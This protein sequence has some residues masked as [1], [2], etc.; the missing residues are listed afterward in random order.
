MKSQ[1]AFAAALVL[2]LIGGASIAKAQTTP[3]VT[4]TGTAKIEQMPTIVRMHI[5]LSGKG[6]AVRE[7]LAGLKDR[8]E[9]ATVNLEALGARKESIKVGE[10]TIGAATDERSRQMEMMIRQRMAGRQRGK[11]PEVKKPVTVTATMT[12]EWV[13]PSGSPED[14]LVAAHELQEKIKAA[15]LAGM[16]EAEKLS[17]EEEELAEEMS[18]VDTYG[19]EEAA[20]PGEPA[21]QYVVRITDDQHKKLVAEAFTKARDQAASLARAAGSQLG[22]LQQLQSHETESMH[23]TEIYSRMGYRYASSPYV[24]QANE[25][26]REAVGDAP[27]KV[28]YQVMINASFGLAP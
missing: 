15:D 24:P 8:R 18:Q 21:F 25:D 20:K 11:K 6:K 10:P 27:G 17:A 1:R 5:Q 22:A 7:A 9:A 3:S 2:G 4:S 28:T 16:K 13:L 14:L 23:E 19:G 26:V 12:A